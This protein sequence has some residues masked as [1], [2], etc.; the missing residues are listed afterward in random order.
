MI[1]EKCIFFWQCVFIARY[2]TT[3][4]VVLEQLSGHFSH[5]TLKTRSLRCKNRSGTNASFK[6]DQVKALI[7]RTD[8]L[9][10]LYIAVD[11]FWN[12]LFHLIDTWNTRSPLI[13][14]SL[15]GSKCYFQVSVQMTL[16]KIRKLS[17]SKVKNHFGNGVQNFH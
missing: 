15:E 14:F 5:K 17:F 10:F 6:F 8:Q 7:W 9:F 1:D 2:S 4:K 3:E 16:C 11:R 12:V 13:G